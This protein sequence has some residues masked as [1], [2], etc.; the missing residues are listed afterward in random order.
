MFEINKRLLPVKVHYFL[1]NGAH[2]GV[3]PFATV[4]AKQLRIPAN[5]VGVIFFFVSCLTLISRTFLG[6]IVD[7]FQKFRTV[8]FVLI[9]ID[10]AA[11]LGLNFIPRP[12]H[13]VQKEHNTNIFCDEGTSYL[14]KFV[15]ERCGTELLSNSSIDCYSCTVCQN[16]S[17]YC[18]KNSTTSKSI[19]RHDSNDI[20][21]ALLDRCTASNSSSC[22]EACYG[23]ASGSLL[24]GFAIDIYGGRETFFW[25]GISLLLVGVVHLVMN[26][27]FNCKIASS[28]GITDEVPQ[29]VPLKGIER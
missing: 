9:I 4:Y 12:Y 22:N 27:A 8:L 21:T 14:V 10:I 18:S 28:Y 25:G 5:E 11:D 29:R 17:E 15:S 19:R 16:E 6:G 20:L 26:A 3:I 7:H 24:G 1:L 2:S 13:Q 23:V